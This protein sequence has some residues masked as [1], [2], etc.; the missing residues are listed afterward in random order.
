MRQ[1]ENFKTEKIPLQK[2]GR[3]MEITDQ[4]QKIHV[5]PCND[6]TREKNPA[7]PTPLME[8]DRGWLFVPNWVF[9]PYLRLLEQTLNLTAHHGDLKVYGDKLIQVQ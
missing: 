6:I 8:R 1:T 4:L 9:L 5:L 2:K 3:G 7:I